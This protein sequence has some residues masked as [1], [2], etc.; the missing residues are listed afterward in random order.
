MK[1]LLTF[2]IIISGYNLFSQVDTALVIL[3]AKMN[4]VSFDD[5]YKNSE[6]LLHSIDS[7][8]KYRVLKS[9]GFNSNVI[10]F[11]LDT[12]N[13]SDSSYFHDVMNQ[14]DSKFIIGY[15]IKSESIYFLKGNQSNDFS[16]LLRDL[17]IALDAYKT[18]KEFSRSYYVENLDLECLFN[19]IKSKN[20]LKFNCLY[21]AKRIGR[22]VS[23]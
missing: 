1:K 20:K 19:S 21:P 10:F 11:E 15:F 6:T 14:F 16:D 5:A 18:G 22:I 9:S 2:L 3:N 7:D 12:Q 13:C 23:W 4:L 17:C 8:I